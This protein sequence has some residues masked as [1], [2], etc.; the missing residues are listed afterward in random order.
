MKLNR[1]NHWEDVYKTK[2]P[3]EV[4][5]TQEVPKISLDF[6]RSFEVDKTAKI[7]DIGGG[8]SKFVDFLL[9]EGYEN[10][11][12]LDISAKSLEKS[13]KRLGDKAKNVTWLTSDVTEFEPDT[14]YDVWHDRATF[15]FL[16]Q[17]EEVAKY[18]A[19]ATRAVSSFLTVG[20]FSENGPE[21]CSGLEI[22]QYSEEKLTTAFKGGFDKIR[23]VAEDH[24]TPFG[25][26][27]NF[28]FCGFRK[29]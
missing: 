23:C 24:A 2:S 1:K 13:Q 28:L 6:I 22:R 18:I 16:T 25:T 11:T 19:I 12:V 10:I 5:W 26:E 21:K 9:D 14:T 7:I 3:N 27:Q 15:H 29:R 4:S 8:D 17:P 20:T